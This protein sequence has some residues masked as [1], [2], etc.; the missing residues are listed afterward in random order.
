MPVSLHAHNTVTRTC[1]H[2]PMHACIYIIILLLFIII[3]YISSQHDQISNCAVQLYTQLKQTLSSARNH[4]CMQCS[5]Y[6]NYTT[7]YH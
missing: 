7:K 6:I 2:R 3:I 5:S 4:A 1:M